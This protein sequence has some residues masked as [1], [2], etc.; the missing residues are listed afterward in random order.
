[1][2]DKITALYC[3]LSQDDMLQG[4][5]NSITNQKA[6][7]KKYAEDNGFGNPVFYVDDGVSGTT[8]ERE[9]FKAM[10]ADVEV[11]KVGIVITKDLSRLG[12][13]YLKTG[14]LIEMV[15]PD[16]DVRYIAIN[17]GVDTLKSENELMA[18]KN[19]FN[20]WYAR[21][22]SKK[23]RAVF[24]A[25]GQSGKHLSNPI[26]GY[27]HSETD[28]NL[29][30]IDEA[31]AEVV[32]KI[33]YLCIDGYGPAQI[34]RILTEQ[35]IPTPTAYALSQG[36]DNGH[37]NA[38]LH[39]W[40]SETIAHILEK[41]EYCGHTVNFR[42]HVKSYKN[43]KRVDNP[44]EE[45]LIFENTHEAIITQQEFDLVQELRRHKHR[46]TKIEEVNPFS[47]VCF[48]ADC[49]RKMYLCRAK[50]LTADQEHLKCGTYANDKDE[51]T[52]H[53]IRT[54]V[55]KEIVLG[56]LNKMISFVKEKED[57]FVQ[58][59]MD[60]SVQKQSSELAKSRKKLKESEKR[61]AELDRLFTRLYE[62]NVSGKISDER[63]SMMSA[64]YEDE[65]KKLKA[66]VTELTAYIE[67]AEQKSADVTAFIKAVQKYEHITE[68]TPE[69]MHELIEK[70][71][72]HAPNKSSGHRTQEI[73]IHYR[74]NV[75]VTT[76]VADSMK[77][78]KKRKAA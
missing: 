19:I 49:G 36:R 14:E 6:I 59:A 15:F 10:M 32:R 41:A 37:K 38:K 54:I 2:T 46:P 31:A 47:G 40:G 33:F 24:K 65:Q 75:A 20:D 69:I 73:E 68:L 72:V 8:W 63:F 52:A 51:C 23:I 43:K 17:D 34:A 27:K 53:F 1:M 18:F 56:E 11:G 35:G 71:V 44:K 21:D 3:R 7:L 70:I 60:N 39:R 61:I 66:S 74:F 26:Y 64:G 22:T 57:E 76:A 13:D 28:K 48:C 58:A 42:T 25:K 77:Y 62:D 50:S 16:Y 78:D 5:S 4:E 29:W 9:G 67:T 45:W 30:V 12:R 55:L